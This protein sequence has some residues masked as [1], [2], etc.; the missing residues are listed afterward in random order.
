MLG[1]V[2]YTHLAENTEIMHLIST[3][4][5]VKT[6]QKLCTGNK[7]VN[8]KKQLPY[9]HHCAHVWSAGHDGCHNKQTK[10]DFVT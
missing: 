4:K 2:N 10:I 1:F 9:L 5:L 8:D 6:P 3:L 7:Q